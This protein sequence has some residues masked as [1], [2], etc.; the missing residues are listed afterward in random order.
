MPKL[1]GTALKVFIGGI[2]IVTGILNLVGDLARKKQEEEEFEKRFNEMYDKRTT[3]IQ[4]VEYEEITEE[5][6]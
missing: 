6:A 2:T 1:G 5:T 3:Q 4:E